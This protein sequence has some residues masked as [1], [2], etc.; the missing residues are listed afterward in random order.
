MNETAPLSY[1]QVPVPSTS[2]RL[3]SGTCAGIAAEIGVAALWVRLAFIVLGVSGGLGI[4]IYGVAWGAMTWNVRSQR[5]TRSH[6]SVEKGA[7]SFNRH[8]GFAMIVIGLV[9][10]AASTGIASLEL[11]WPAPI[12]SALVVVWD[13]SGGTRMD[14]FGALQV[15]GGLAVVIVGF[16]LLVQN[17]VTVAGSVAAVVAGLAVATGLAMLS[18]PWWWGLVQ[19]LDDERQARARSD[20]RADVAA[21]LHDSVLQTLSLIQRAGDDPKKMVALARRQEREL[22]NWLDPDRVSRTGGSLRGRMDEVVTE[23]EDLHGISVEMVMV[24][25]A[26]VGPA[27]DALVAATR[28]AVFNTAK[29]AD[30]SRVDVYVEVAQG[31][32]TVFVRDTGVGFDPADVPS[33]R[34]G[35]SASIRDRM[36]RAGGA[37]LITSAPGEGT[38]VEL[39]VPI[40]EVRA[41][42]D[43]S[44]DSGLAE[45]PADH[46]ENRSSDV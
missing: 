23:V 11:M 19:S 36:K 2:D 24:G 4:A 18:A 21:H 10:F 13:R 29:H 40:E 45:H 34:R 20:E 42:D 43:P 28:E 17:G 7:T 44:P 37:A 25:D 41:P 31:D 27:I 38:E 32:A 3:I 33:D 30:V 12:L 46:H 6:D 5:W 1:W 35:L 22:R 26:P 15:V 16:V 39:S 8:L 9:W 14:R